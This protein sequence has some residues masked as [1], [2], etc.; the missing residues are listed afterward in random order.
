MPENEFT[1]STF[2]EAVETMVRH[3][4]LPCGS[5]TKPHVPFMIAAWQAK[6]IQLGNGTIPDVCMRCGVDFPHQEI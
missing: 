5:P 6:L 1:A 2:L 4:R 3:D